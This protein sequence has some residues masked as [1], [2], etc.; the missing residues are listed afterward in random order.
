MS[1]GEFKAVF[2]AAIRAGPGSRRKAFDELENEYGDTFGRGADGFELYDH[3]LAWV[4]ASGS[5]DAIKEYQRRF[6]GLCD[7]DLLRKEVI[8]ADTAAVDQ[9]TEA[10]EIRQKPG[11]FGRL[12]G[13]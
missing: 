11:F 2:V 7:Q 9:M 5:E 10:K 3:F 4:R 8:H 13:R 1:I 12:F 6:E